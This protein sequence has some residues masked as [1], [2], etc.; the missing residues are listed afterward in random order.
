[1]L[2]GAGGGARVGAPD[3][4]GARGGPLP[5]G[6]VQEPFPQVR[7]DVLG[8]LGEAAAAGFDERAGRLGDVAGV[9]AEDHRNA[10]ARGLEQVVAPGRDQSAA[11]ESRRGPGVEAAE[12]A[13]AVDEKAIDPLPGREGAGVQLG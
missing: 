9:G 3:G 8:L 5:R 10:Q 2:E 1:M 13:E 12:R 7:G 6:G 11:D 4:S